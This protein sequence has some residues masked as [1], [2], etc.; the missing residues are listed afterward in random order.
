METNS[1][2]APH[3]SKLIFFNVIS[4]PPRTEPERANLPLPNAADTAKPKHVKR[5]VRNVIRKEPSSPAETASA[6]PGVE[7]I[8]PTRGNGTPAEAETPVAKSITENESAPTKSAAPAA[9]RVI[10]P[11]TDATNLK[12]P[13][14]A[15]PVMSRRLREQGRVV[16]DVHVQADG[17]VGEVRLRHSSGYTRLDQAAIK[18]VR[19]WRY[20]PARQSDLPISYWY[21]QPVVFALDE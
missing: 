10:P 19:V 14:P 4:G 1:R 18:A 21:A 3:D 7:P 11:H 12:N 16:L 13:V 5:T 8:S 9:E 20:V 2:Q 6:V 17:S 15:Y